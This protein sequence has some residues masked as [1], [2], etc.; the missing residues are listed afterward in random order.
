MVEIPC[1]EAKLRFVMPAKAGLLA[2]QNQRPRIRVSI[3]RTE[4]AI[5]FQA[6]NSETHDM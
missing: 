6:K 3:E 1:L 4:T 5:C 2:L